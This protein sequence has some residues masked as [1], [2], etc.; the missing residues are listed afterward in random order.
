MSYYFNLLV[1]V[2]LFI[3]TPTLFVVSQNMQFI[4]NQL[5]PFQDDREDKVLTLEDYA[6]FY[7]DFF[8]LPEV[9][10]SGDLEIFSPDQ[11]ERMVR[12]L[13][14]LAKN[15]VLSDQGGKAAILEYDIRE[16]LSDFNFDV[17][18]NS[19]IK[20]Y[21]IA[22]PIFERQS[23]VLCN[24]FSKKEK[25]T[26]FC[27]RYRKEVMIGFAVVISVAALIVVISKVEKRPLSKQL[28]NKHKTP[29]CRNFKNNMRDVSIKKRIVDNITY[30]L[31]ETGEVDKDIF[32]RDDGCYALA[33]D[34][35]RYAA[36]KTSHE[37]IE[38]VDDVFSATP[39]FVDEIEN[40][41]ASNFPEW[42]TLI[43]KIFSTDLANR[44]R[45]RVY[46]S[47][48]VEARINE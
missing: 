28:R 12:L 24:R 5:I 36:S 30:V 17:S 13:A 43:D 10:E 2:I 41:Q 21:A 47:M 38:E 6:E 34:V 14:L 4:D 1:H 9:L 20:D 16:L 40:I 42:L 29:T 45:K 48:V 8:G 37:L 18:R 27:Q 23:N 7:D 22:P 26:H 11:L 39:Y 35:L 15:G 25:I 31:K 19:Q 46:E 32:H 3:T 44:Y 33:E